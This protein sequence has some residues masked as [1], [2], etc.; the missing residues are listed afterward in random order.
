MGLLATPVL[1]EDRPVPDPGGHSDEEDPHVPDGAPDPVPDPCGGNAQGVSHPDGQ[2]PVLHDSDAYSSP[3][4]LPPRVLRRA[5]GRSRARLLRNKACKRR[6]HSLA[7]PP[8]QA[9]RDVCVQATLTEAP[10]QLLA[11]QPADCGVPVPVAA[12]VPPAAEDHHADVL[13]D[14]A[15]HASGDGVREF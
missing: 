15:P 9:T 2:R 11:A 12:N 5:P 8:L 14:A 1:P 3:D 6:L 4:D 10:H 7:Y 13:P